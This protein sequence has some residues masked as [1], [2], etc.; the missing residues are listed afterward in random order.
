MFKELGQF[1]T[2]HPVAVIAV[3]IIILLAAVPLAITFGDRLS[4]NMETFIPDDL[5]SVKTG[6]VYESLFPDTAKSQ[7]IVAVV[8]ENKTASALFI[9]ELNQ[10]INNGSVKNITST[11]SIYDIQREALVNASPD[12]HAGLHDLYNNTTSVNR[13]LYNAT[14]DLADASRDVYYLRDNVTKINSELYTAWGQAAGA[15]QQM[16][17]ARAGIETAYD[18][19]AQMK[20]IGDVLFGLPAGYARAWDDIGAAN[21]SMDEGARKAAAYN[22]IA[23]TVPS[24]PAQ[25]LAIGYL[26]AFNSTWTTPSGSSVQHASDIVKGGFAANFINSAPASAEEKQMMQAILDSFP[27]IQAYQD[28]STRKNVFVGMVMSQGGMTSDADRARMNAIYDQVESGNRDIDGL[29]LGFVTAGMDGD[30]ASQARELYGLGNDRNRIG[31]YVVDKAVSAQNNSTVKDLIR[32]AWNLGP[33]ATNETFDKYI[34]GKATEDMN[35]SEK[36]DFLVIYGWGPNPGATVI[37]DYVLGKAGEDL[38]QTERDFL[39]DVYDLGDNPGDA[40]VK[41]F[42]VGKV[43]DELN[44]TGNLSYMYALLDLDRNATKAEVEAFAAD[45]A[46]THD[47]TNPQLM[48]DSVV[49]NLAAGNL[50]MFVVST[51]DSDESLSAKNNVIAIRACVDGLESRPEYGE[52]DAHVTGSTAMS[53]DAE[54]AAMA[55]VNNIDRI[56]I[57]LILILLGLYFRS[58]LTPF[59]PLLTI[60]IA[61]V[62]AFGG[63]TLLS[64]VMP[65]YSLIMTFVMVIMLGAGT[66]YCVFLLS[67]YSEERSKGVEQKESI[68]TAVEHAGKSIV[69]SGSTAMIGFGALLLV[70]RGI[71]GG[72]GI[73]VAVGIFC[74]ILVATTLLPAVLTLV[75][76]RLFW[77]RKLYNSGDSSI[78]KNLWSRITRQVLKHSRLVLIAAILVSIPAVLLATQITLGNDFVSMMSPGI[79]SKQGFDAINAAMG[80]GSIDRVMILATLP[81]NVTDASGNYTAASLDTIE[82]LS[83]VIAGIHSID[84]VNS[85]TRPEG[86]TINY[87]NLSVYSM[88]EK[89]YYRSYMTD[90]LGNDDRTVVLYASFKGSPYSDENMQSVD[91]IRAKLADYTAATG[92]TTMVG[93]SVAGIYDY[94]KSCTS[95]YPLVYLAVFVGI[96]LVL[97][98]VLRSVFTPLRLIIT[99]LMSVVWTLGAYVLIMQIMFG[100]VTSWILPIFLFCALMG[101]GVDYDIFLVSRVREEVMKGKSDEEAIETAVEST[102]S[103][104]TLCGAV[105]ASAFG[106]MLLSTSAE[107]QEFGFVLSL[108]IILDATVIRLML[109]PA[110]MV[111]MK[112]YNWW[113]PFVGHAKDKRP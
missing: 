63:L 62:A 60:G 79:E 27:S 14:R 102:G 86:A 97:A 105:M 77:P 22:Q 49:K 19:M 33:Q 75:G 69:S 8:S 110:I 81:Q 29:T 26:Q 73:S 90:S 113:M 98:A 58:F 68:I 32:D 9:D 72:I 59:V 95:N 11:S 35:E 44:L 6:D 4:Y 94:Q 30:A 18:G 89:E 106:S 3:W 112:K 76:D 51:S 109:V 56:A 46:A 103:I 107:L 12:L 64:Y 61:I 100:Y 1:I 28:A 17:D 13:E 45:W 16:Y 5:E 74:A 99:L 39:A 7:I 92:V 87:N 65:M 2:R 88:T 42:V 40:T 43:N 53:L 21:T 55:D 66:D 85:P 48:P 25:Q 47:Y 20:G 84:K 70:D 50:T 36:A 101:L 24:G 91:E 83:G 38:N 111:L 31:S 54:A 41:A 23:G 57:V 108:A 15:S 80:S 37:R 104:I 96:F 93:G 34:I 52:V 10:S 78:V 67:R 71:F 82:H